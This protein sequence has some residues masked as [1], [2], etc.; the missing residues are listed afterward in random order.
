MPFYQYVTFTRPDT[1]TPWWHE[2]GDPSIDTRTQ[3]KT[4]QSSVFYSS[5]SPSETVSSDN[6]TKVVTTVFNSPQAYLDYRTALKASDPEIFTKRN[7]FL[8]ATKQSML[9]EWNED[10]SAPRNLISKTIPGK[11]VEYG[12][13]TLPGGLTIH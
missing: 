5:I 8:I 13:T 9:V 7:R 6:L 3:V 1:L 10:P 12:S 2:S 11:P 4:A